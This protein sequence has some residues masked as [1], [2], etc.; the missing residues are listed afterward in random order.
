LAEVAAG[1]APWEAPVATLQV[2]KETTAESKELESGAQ[3]VPTCA[4]DLL[5]I[6]RTSG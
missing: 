4:R 1:L 3:R 6:L 2:V 5:Y